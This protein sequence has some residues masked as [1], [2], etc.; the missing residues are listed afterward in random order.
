MAFLRQHTHNLYIM[1]ELFSALQKDIRRGNVNNV[2]F[3]GGEFMNNGNPLPLWNRLFVIACEDISI[4]QP[5]TSIVLWDLYNK[6]KQTLKKEGVIIKNSYTSKT[7]SQYIIDALKY[8]TYAHKNRVINN[9]TAYLSAAYK[10]DDVLVDED[11]LPVGILSDVSY[12][13]TTLSPA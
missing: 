2:L 4:G 5:H 13:S 6:W 8:C 10:L 7:A 3:W 1:D 11:K 12:I 9:L